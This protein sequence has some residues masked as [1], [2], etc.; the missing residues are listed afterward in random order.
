MANGDKDFS[1]LPAAGSFSF[2]QDFSDT[3][4]RFYWDK[5]ETAARSEALQGFLKHDG[6]VANRVTEAIENGP[7]KSDHGDEYETLSIHTAAESA[8]SSQPINLPLQNRRI[9][10]DCSKIL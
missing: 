6:D 2:P 9:S 10:R 5:S 8:G 1:D 7:H 4:G 3:T